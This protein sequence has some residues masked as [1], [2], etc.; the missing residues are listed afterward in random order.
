[1]E[2]KIHVANHECNEK[3]LYSFYSAKK[4]Y[5]AKTPYKYYLLEKKKSSQK[6]VSL[7]SRKTILT[8]SKNGML[9]FPEK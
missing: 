5:F 6:I 4:I 7:T 2:S 3:T 9:L 8:N 1:M